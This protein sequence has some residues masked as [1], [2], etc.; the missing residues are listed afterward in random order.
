M[1]AFYRVADSWMSGVHKD[2]EDSKWREGD[3]VAHVTG[4]KA[5]ERVKA[6][7]MFGGGCEGIEDHTRGMVLTTDGRKVVG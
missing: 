1:N 7:D 4:M 5:E 6:A 3:W 2:Q